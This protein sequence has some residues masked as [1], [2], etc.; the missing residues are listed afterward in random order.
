MIL[1]PKILVVVSL[2]C[3]AFLCWGQFKLLLP[4]SI[5]YTAIEVQQQRIIDINEENDNNND[6]NT[7]LCQLYAP[8]CES[9]EVV[10]QKWNYQAEYNQTWCCEE[11][12]YLRQAVL[13]MWDALTELRVPAW[14]ESG[15]ALG[16]ARHNGTQIP[17]EYDADISIIVST[18]PKNISM[19]V[20]P[21][22]EELYTPLVLENGKKKQA[23]KW[24]NRMLSRLQSNMNATRHRQNNPY[25]TR[26]ES[27]EWTYRFIKFWGNGEGQFNFYKHWHLVDNR[28]IISQ[29]DLFAVMPV[30]EAKVIDG[31]MRTPFGYGPKKHNDKE[32]Q[33]Y[34]FPPSECQFVS[35]LLFLVCGVASKP[36][37]CAATNQNQLSLI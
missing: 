3:I 34:Q 32:Y 25:S 22:P 31:I 37:Q 15:S 18:D 10:R 19:G 13:E 6:G 1:T 5:F 11:H 36:P 33:Y 14:M 7:D 29:V 30:G 12:V 21:Y 23:K 27:V 24:C 17:W 28:T 16:I 9:L 35:K 4:V 8:E 2:F 20:V 26:V